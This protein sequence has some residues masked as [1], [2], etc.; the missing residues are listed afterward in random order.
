MTEQL[1]TYAGLLTLPLFSFNSLGD[2]VAVKQ[3]NSLLYSSLYT[4]EVAELKQ[5]KQLN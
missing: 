2:S 5:E 4:I 1:D 3:Q